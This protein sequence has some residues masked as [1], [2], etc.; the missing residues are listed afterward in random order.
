MTRNPFQNATLPPMASTPGPFDGR[1][2]P[3][4]DRATDRQIDYL[5]SLLQERDW[6]ADTLAREAGMV[7]EYMVPGLGLEWMVAKSMASAAIRHL[8][9]C[10][11]KAAPKDDLET[12]EVEDGSYALEFDG[13]LRFFHVRSPKNGRWV[14][15]TFV[16]EK[17]GPEEYAVRDRARR[18][19]ILEA[20]AADP[21]ALARYGQELGICGRCHRELT[22][23][24]SRAAG[25]GPICRSK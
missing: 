6:D 19:R 7:A 25:L 24:V 11:R 1:K 12:P 5:R 9:V 3:A 8:K 23:E 22:D 17:A 10:P 13:Q 18:Q 2:T 20:I 14:G 16:E 21:D 4:A 15:Y